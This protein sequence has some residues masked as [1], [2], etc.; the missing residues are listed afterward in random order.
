MVPGDKEAV[1]LYLEV[2]H[3]APQ[4]LVLHLQVSET[5][6]RLPQLSLQLSLQL[7]TAL[8]ELLQLLLGVHVAGHIRE[9]KQP[10]VSTPRDARSTVVPITVSGKDNRQY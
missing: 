7:S 3:L 6:L 2:V 9:I 4:P 8:L 1:F 5:V 10:F